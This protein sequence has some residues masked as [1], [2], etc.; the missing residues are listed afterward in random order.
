LTAAPF[1]SDS[2]A[3]ADLFVVSVEGMLRDIDSVEASRAADAG[4][5]ADPEAGFVSLAT[6]N[7]AHD[8]VGLQSGATVELNTTEL[9][10]GTYLGFRAIIDPARSSVTL[11]DGT[12][13]R[14]NTTPGILWPDPARV[15]VRLELDRP[16]MVDDLQATALLLDFDLRRLFVRQG[17]TIAGGLRFVTA[18][19]G[20]IRDSTGSIEGTVRR[21][22][23]TGA[24]VAGA[25]IEVLRP[26]T[27]ISDLN[28]A[29][30]VRSGKTTPS[31]TFAIP[32]LAPGPYALRAVPPAS[33]PANGPAMIQVV[34]AV[35][36]VRADG[37][38]LV[39]PH[40]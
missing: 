26:N 8:M 17:P 2:V 21:D 6:P 9:P 40:N 15:G 20:A 34:T 12:V 29:N 30:I 4:D 31:G 33:L 27:P 16:V 11:T 32:F 14:G 37:N 10:L 36:G 35:P 24:P 1:G 23:A 18:L 22:D 13:L 28:P 39:L 19:R 3:R 38:L 5:N 25:I 7:V